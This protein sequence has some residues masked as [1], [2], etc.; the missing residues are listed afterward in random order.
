MG[1]TRDS[2]PPTTGSKV[3]GPSIPRYLMTIGR[4]LVVVVVGMWSCGGKMGLGTCGFVER[5]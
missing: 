3:G 5:L 4:G 2:G 1:R